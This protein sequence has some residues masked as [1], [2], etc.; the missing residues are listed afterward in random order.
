MRSALP[1]KWGN[2]PGLHHSSTGKSTASS[3]PG[4][5]APG[6]RA[7]LTAP[8]A[9]GGRKTAPSHGS[10]Q[11]VSPLV[12]PS[13]MGP[14]LPTAQTLST[15]RAASTAPLLRAA[16]STGSYAPSLPAASGLRPTGSSDRTVLRSRCVW[17]MRS[18][19]QPTTSWDVLSLAATNGTENV[20]HESRPPR[21]L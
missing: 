8:N 14:A 21:K 3:L 13:A 12:S 2:S 6:L 4:R 20:C 16:M 1:G 19:A 15:P 17:R 5:E 10:A 9:E 11:P 18:S 7:T